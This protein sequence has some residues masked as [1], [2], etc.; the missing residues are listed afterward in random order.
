MCELHIQAQHQKKISQK[1]W[2]EERTRLF[3]MCPVTEQ[4]TM[5]TNRNTRDTV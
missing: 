1:E 2:K 5:G 4:E 3:A